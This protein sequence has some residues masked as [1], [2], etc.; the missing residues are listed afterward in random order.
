[1]G[2]LFQSNSKLKFIH[3]LCP[4]VYIV[5]EYNW[6]IIDLTIMY[7]FVAKCT[8]IHLICVSISSLELNITIMQ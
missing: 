6:I 7:H 8:A 3:A 4:L 2:I 1:M 5:L